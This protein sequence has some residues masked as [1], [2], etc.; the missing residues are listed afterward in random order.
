M[1]IASR[2]LFAPPLLRECA[3]RWQVPP[4]PEA[5]LFACGNTSN[6]S[7]MK[8][9]CSVSFPNGSDRAKANAALLPDDR[10]SAFSKAGAAKLIM[11]FWICPKGGEREPP[12]S[13]CLLEYPSCLHRPLSFS[14]YKVHH[15]SL[16]KNLP[17]LFHHCRDLRFL[18]DGIIVAGLTKLM[19]KKTVNES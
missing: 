1:D 7:H 15:R 18:D 8:P 14:I 10:N 2:S 5:S 11:L 17:F 3:M 19:P 16:Q 6:R 13:P 12:Q 9:V 4:A